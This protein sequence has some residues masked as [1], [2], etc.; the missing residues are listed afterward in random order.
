MVMTLFS[1][2]GIIGAFVLPIMIFCG[3]SAV[4][5]APRQKSQLALRSKVLDRNEQYIE[6]VTAVDANGAPI[7]VIRLHRQF[8]QHAD[9]DVTRP[10]EF[11]SSYVG[12]IDIGSPISQPLLVSFDTSSG[13][14]MLPALE[15]QSP[16]CQEHRRYYAAASNTSEIVNANG[17]PAQGSGRDSVEVGIS[18][19]DFGDGR[20]SGELIHDS[21][22]LGMTNNNSRS[23]CN[24]VGLVVA[25]S[26]NQ[27]PFQHMP[28]DGIFGLGLETL[29]VGPTFNFLKHVEKSASRTPIFGIFLSE[30]WGEISFGGYREERL[31]SPLIWSHVPS[32]LVHQGF[33][34]VAISAIRVG[35]YTLD[36]CP[37]T[38][39]SGIIDTT[40]SKLGVAS[41][42]YPIIHDAFAKTSK[43]TAA[44]MGGGHCTGQDL[45]IDIAL[46]GGVETLTLRP[47]D[48]S[49][50]SSCK[51]L[52]A[53]VNLPDDFAGVLILGTPLLRRYYTV[54]DRDGD[55][56]AGPRVGF[57]LA[58]AVS[59][60]EESAVAAAHVADMEDFN[61]ASAAAMSAAAEVVAAV[62]QAA[63]HNTNTVNFESDL[64]QKLS[65]WAHFCLLQ[66]LLSMI[67]AAP[68]V[69][70]LSAL[71]VKGAAL[72]DVMRL[73]R[74]K[75]VKE[76]PPAAEC[77]ICLGSCEED[78]CCADAENAEEGMRSQR[79]AVKPRWS[80]LRCEHSFH[81]GCILQWLKRSNRCPVCR[82]PA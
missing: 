15:C 59:A 3:R 78:I 58:A 66:L 60:G 71:I 82:S 21:V 24:E 5:A 27:V 9:G 35:N 40:A 6:P 67:M 7:H 49:D 31:A 48:Y 79:K 17:T 20:L 76:P 70:R 44:D 77:S 81:E 4:R 33:W 37:R 56:G 10:S 62:A 36:V 55:A 80:K 43:T 74:L 52:L 29:S 23:F 26:M 39:C 19:M 41:Q 65:F 16:A 46:N 30:T 61:V 63:A 14:L 51:P 75:Q 1:P 38:G 68:N 42:M 47:S 2:S 12:R 34:Q 32:K 54:F 50:G 64:F 53:E 11:K 28:Q 57:G 22:C 18:S 25:T 45:H 72:T 69:V 8:E 73:S 13:N